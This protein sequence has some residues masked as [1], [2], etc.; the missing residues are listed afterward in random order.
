MS[1]QSPDIDERSETHYGAW[2]KAQDHSQ[3]DAEDELA[4]DI[5]GK[6]LR[7]T[8]AQESP[9]PNAALTAYYRRSL[10]EA[11]DEVT[12]R[13]GD[14]PIGGTEKPT[15]GWKT[16]VYNTNRKKAMIP[17]GHTGPANEAAAKK[18]PWRTGRSSKRPAN[19][20]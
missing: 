9:G 6:V 7:P 4:S 15:S 5:L 18:P 16:V 10:K 13:N 19:A 2:G 8:P 12:R 11:V 1:P 20:G 14:P 17:A 3:T